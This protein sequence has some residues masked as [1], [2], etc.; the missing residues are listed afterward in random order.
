MQRNYDPSKDI[1]PAPIIKQIQKFIDEGN[2]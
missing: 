1:D 2:R